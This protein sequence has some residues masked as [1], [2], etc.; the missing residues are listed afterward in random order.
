MKTVSIVISAHNEEK[1][2]EECLRSATFADEILVI[3]SSSTDQT[4]RIAREYTKK[5]FMRKNNFMLNSNKNYGF[6]KATGDWIV[7]LDADERISKELAEEIK[8]ALKKEDEITGYWIPRKN[9]IFG[10]WIQH[11]GWYPDLQLRLFRKEKGKFAERHVHEMISLEGKSKELK[12]HLIHY[13]YDSVSQF[14]HKLFT[15]YAPNEA[16]QLIEKG[17]VF[18]W[19]DALRFPFDEFLS[20]FFA[21]EGYKDGLHGLVLSLGMSF[22]HF[23][24]FAYIWEHIGFKEVEK[25][26]ISPELKKE[27]QAIGKETAHWL[28]TTNQTDSQPRTVK[29][30]IK[31]FFFMKDVS[32]ITINY[33]SSKHTIAL[34]SSLSHIGKKRISSTIVVDNKSQDESVDK[35]SSFLT[36]NDV[37]NAIFIKNGKNRGFSGGNN[38]GINKALTGGC[39]YILLINNDTILDP[40]LIDELVASMEEDKEIGIV[41]PKIYF[42][43]GYEYHKERYRESELGKVIWYAGGLIDWENVIGSHRGVDE[44]D[45][46]QFDKKSE[47]DFASGC[48]MMIKREVFEKI[49]LFNEDYFLYYEDA[50]FS[51]RAKKM[52]FKIMYE[53]KGVLWHK[54]AGSTGGSGSS[55]QDYY[56]SRNRLLF[57]MKYAS[58]RIKTFLVKESFL[59]ILKGR[60]WQKRGVIDFYLNRFGKGS[61]SV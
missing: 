4:N 28:R 14:I 54:N 6:Q 37:P 45:R 20:R 22:Y 11:S 56:I 12:H 24:V 61:Y 35:I 13:N 40:N 10:K 38:D 39:K 52:G 15:I 21:R 59:L 53:P 44:L 31:S 49:G 23:I 27:F 5:V 36:K 33:N 50:E 1:K 29:E 2:I 42:A 55:L 8:D 26:E 47:T 9:I 32:I 43:K 3:D 58:L 7:S 30:V 16:E 19:Q 18:K 46:G 34:L 48:C 41:S 51:Q 25:S 17:Y 60:P 57:G